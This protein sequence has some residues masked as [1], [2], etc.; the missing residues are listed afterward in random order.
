MLALCG[1]WSIVGAA[2]I[3]DYLFLA[4]SHYAVRTLTD[5]DKRYA[6][7]EKEMLAIVYALEKFEDYTF[8]RLTHVYS[9]HKPLIMI[10]DKAFHRAPRRLQS[11]LIRL[12]KY[13]Y[14]L[15]YE[16][17]KRM[18]VADTLS[19]ATLP[20]TG[21]EQKLESVNVALA[22]TQLELS[23]IRTATIDDSSMQELKGV[24]T[25]GW[26]KNKKSLHMD[27]L[28]YFKFRDEL[29]VHDELIFRGKRPAEGT[30]DNLAPARVVGR[31]CVHRFDYMHPHS[32]PI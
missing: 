30:M 4:P 24:I 1:R 29:T 18:F 7:I 25:R 31:G 28:P 12:Q 13:N 22:V 9:D 8:G 27:V 17:G 20:D 3:D 6:Q 32:G 10:V 26:P 21:Q 15:H 5:C 16:Q 14:E 2:P 23:H 19:R 11:M